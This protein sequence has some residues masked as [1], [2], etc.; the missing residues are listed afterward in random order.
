M[1][2]QLRGEGPVNLLVLDCDETTPACAGMA[3]WQ[4]EAS[5]P[6]N[7]APDLLGHGQLALTL[8]ALS[9]CVSRLNQAWMPMLVGDSSPPSSSTT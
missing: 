7:R 9:S 5:G 6:A 4:P 2:F 1:T 8:D 3:H